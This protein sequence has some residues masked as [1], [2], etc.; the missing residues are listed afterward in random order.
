M[1]INQIK[2]L[3]N[4]EGYNFIHYKT[5]NS[6]MN[7]IKKLIKKKKQNYFIIADEQTGGIGRRGN[8]WYS[9]KGNIYFS[10]NQMMS[11]KIEEHFIYNALTTLV[12]SKTVDMICK[13]NSKIKWPNDV[14][15]NGKKISGVITEIIKVNEVHYIIIGVGINYES[16]PNIPTNPTTYLKE[17][18]SNIEM[19]DVIKLFMID[20]VKKINE[21]SNSTFEKILNEYKRKLLYIDN[22]INLEV[23]NSSNLKGRFE[24]VNLDGSLLININGS[25]KNIY[26]AR[27]IND[28]Y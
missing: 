19:L 21:I 28:S 2:K 14:I 20:F 10:F 18:N 4:N 13:I 27:I 15:V 26:S 23:E 5:I 3:I 24:D 16:S 7:E 11:V 6:T 25:K 1:K 8:I 9:P 12:I 17:I 22:Y